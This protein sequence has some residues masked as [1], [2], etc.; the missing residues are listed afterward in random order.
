VLRIAAWRRTGNRTTP[1]ERSLPFVHFD[2]TARL[3]I[4]AIGNRA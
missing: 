1:A 3:S 2:S 4:R